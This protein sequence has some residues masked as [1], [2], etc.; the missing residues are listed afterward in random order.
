MAHDPQKLSLVPGE[1]GADAAFWL[2]KALASATLLDLKRQWQQGTKLYR[3][4][5]ESACVGAFLLRVD[6]T[7][8]GP[9]GVI[10]AAAAELDGVD[11]VQTCLPAIEA[12][13]CGV[14]SIRFHTAKPA[15]A[16]KMARM[17]YG[18][19]ELICVKELAA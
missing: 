7:A 5:H 2:A 15:V 4:M 8:K 1:W 16:R 18:P 14:R 3:V 19:Q 6:S 17:G 11:M 13:F 12:R 9:Q 10:V